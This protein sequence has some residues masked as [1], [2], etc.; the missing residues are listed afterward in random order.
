MQRYKEKKTLTYIKLYWG[1]LHLH[2][3]RRTPNIS[4]APSNIRVITVI[5]QTRSSFT[6]S[7][8]GDLIYMT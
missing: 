4:C 2:L 7:T 6:I 3:P 1:F 5:I 8:E